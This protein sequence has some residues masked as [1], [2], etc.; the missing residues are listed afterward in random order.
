[1]HFSALQ[2]ACD[3]CRQCLNSRL[4]ETQA[5]RVS[6]SAM[7]KEGPRTVRV[8]RLVLAK[9]PAGAAGLMISL[10]PGDRPDQR[11]GTLRRNRSQ[12]PG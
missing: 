10:L 9:L 12:P 4:S 5:V 7:G 6:L 11:A 1:M 3:L 8:D 2:T